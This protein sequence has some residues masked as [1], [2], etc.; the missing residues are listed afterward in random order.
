MKNIDTSAKARQVAKSMVDLL[1]NAGFEVLA[2]GIER[3]EQVRIAKE[4]GVDRIQGFYYARPMDAQSLIE[5][6]KK[7]N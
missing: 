4:M 1:H 2:E 3:E 6:L 7:E 5:F